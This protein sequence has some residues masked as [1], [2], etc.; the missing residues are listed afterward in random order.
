MVPVLVAAALAAPAC[1]PTVDLGPTEIYTCAGTAHIVR[2]KEVVQV[3]NEG[4]LVKVV[5]VAEG[6]ATI[7]LGAGRT[8]RVVV[9]T[10][11]ARIPGY[12]SRAAQGGIP[13]LHFECVDGWVYARPSEPLG[14]K[15]TATLRGWED[16][17]DFVYAAGP[18]PDDLALRVEVAY[19]RRAT[20]D[21]WG[22]GIADPTA[23]FE[24]VVAHVRQG[25]SGSSGALGLSGSVGRS[26]L[27]QDWYDVREVPV[28][29]GTDVMVSFGIETER[30]TRGGGYASSEGSRLRLTLTD[31]V[32]LSGGHQIR[33]T[34]GVD[35]SAPEPSGGPGETRRTLSQSSTVRLPYD[36][37]VTV[38]TWAP[39]HPLSVQTLVGGLDRSS[40]LG[41]ILGSGEQRNDQAFLWV[42]TRLVRREEMGSPTGIDGRWPTEAGG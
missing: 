19:L 17:E 27:R 12:E 41:A 23:L 20:L 11:R 13:G 38:A 25:A 26:T 29:Q 35:W 2:G 9:D 40:P 3:R 39:N 18:P 21:R 16:G 6:T 22:L 7:E 14:S 8:M 10:C 34:L 4:G 24:T 15:H 37:S 28:T 42:V 33:G 30:Y 5:P 1:P 36:Q 32:S 31:V